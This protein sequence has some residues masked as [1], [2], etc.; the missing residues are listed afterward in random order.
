MFYHFFDCI[1]ENIMHILFITYLFKL[2]FLKLYLYYVYLL[3]MRIIKQNK[4]EK[5]NLIFQ[6]P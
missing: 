5:N 1:A 3:S 6:V 4:H 2:S